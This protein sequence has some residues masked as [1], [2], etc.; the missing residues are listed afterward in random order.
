M[1]TSKLCKNCVNASSDF[2]ENNKKLPAAPTGVL[3][4]KKIPQLIWPLSKVAAAR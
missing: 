4:K 2:E 3:Q 1:C